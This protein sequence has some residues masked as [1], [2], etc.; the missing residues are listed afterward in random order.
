[1]AN[2]DPDEQDEDVKQWLEDIEPIIKMNQEIRSE[3]QSSDD[4]EDDK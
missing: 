1:M 2:L 4:S 3:Q